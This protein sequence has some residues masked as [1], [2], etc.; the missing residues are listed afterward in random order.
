MLH[1]L[2]YGHSCP[3]KPLLPVSP[4][5]L[6]TSWS[7]HNDR[8]IIDA[9]QTLPE[10]NI[11]NQLELDSPTWRVRK[12]DPK[13]LNQSH[14]WAQRNAKVGTFFH[15]ALRNTEIEPQVALGPSLVSCQH[16]KT[17]SLT[18]WQPPF[19]HHYCVNTVVLC[20]QRDRPSKCVGVGGMITWALSA[21]ET[22]KSHLS[23]VLSILNLLW[24]CE[25]MTHAEILFCFLVWNIGSSYHNLGMPSSHERF[26]FNEKGRVLE[27]CTASSR[28]FIISTQGISN[29]LHLYQRHILTT[30]T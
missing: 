10:L 11:W 18:V 17:D 12:L 9:Q 30:K 29:R 2:L 26:C 21:V 22:N 19:C 25:G 20:R 1:H 24:C 8:H 14:W 3:L 16:Q 6:H 27:N 4:Q 5:F 15:M 7:R 13:R 28:G 23:Y